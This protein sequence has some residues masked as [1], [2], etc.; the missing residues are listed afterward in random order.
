MHSQTRKV[1]LMGNSQ[2]GKTK[3]LHENLFMASK[4]SYSPTIGASVHPH[5]VGNVTLSIWD[6]AGV[7]ALEK[8]DYEK[9]THGCLY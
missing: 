9:V 3:F 4:W 2:T 6:T 5:T 7:K 8:S 1:V